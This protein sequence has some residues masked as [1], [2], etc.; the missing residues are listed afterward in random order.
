VE[1]PGCGDQEPSRECG[2]AIC[3]SHRLRD[4]PIRGQQTADLID[5]LGSIRNE[6]AA[7]TVQALCILLRDRFLRNEA[8]AGPANGFA[9][10]F[11]IAGVV[12]P[13]LHMRLHER[14][15]HQPH[16]V[17][18]TA[19]SARPLRSLQC[20]PRRLFCTAVNR[21]SRWEDRTVTIVWHFSSS[22]VLLIIN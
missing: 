19:K 2:F 1:P 8:H 20:S 22:L 11:R 16:R 7:D 5:E 15:R 9:N 6:P 14:R 18:Q 10:R 4:D 13:R 3:A 21:L 17:S 12:L